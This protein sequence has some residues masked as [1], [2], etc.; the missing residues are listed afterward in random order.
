MGAI[1]DLIARAAGRKAE[2]RAVPTNSAVAY[3]DSGRVGKA[4][5]KL[6]RH[7]SEHSELVG[8]AI[9]IR[10]GQVAVAEW[11]ILPA[12]PELP[13]SQTLKTQIKTLFDT[14]NPA[15][16]SFRNLTEPIV[17]DILVLD[18]GSIE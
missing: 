11:D 6:F 10:R 5:V 2:E 16:N 17:E 7:W 13:Y 3:G 1:A 4:N 15:R 18:A 12:D 9:D 8:G 14:P